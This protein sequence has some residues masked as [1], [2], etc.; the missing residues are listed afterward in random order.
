MLKKHEDYTGKDKLVFTEKKGKLK[1]IF[2][3]ILSKTL[4]M[5]ST[6]KVNK[7]GDYNQ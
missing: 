4:I 6:L 3:F 5:T 2:F 1:G 7:S